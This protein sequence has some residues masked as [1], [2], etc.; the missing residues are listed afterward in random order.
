MFTSILFSSPDIDPLAF[1]GQVS[2][3]AGDTKMSMHEWHMLE[4]KKDTSQ[5]LLQPDGEQRERYVQVLLLEFFCCNGLMPA[6]ECVC[7][8]FYSYVL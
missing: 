2:L 6:L 3:G 4:K 8:L 7:V 5:V 1:V